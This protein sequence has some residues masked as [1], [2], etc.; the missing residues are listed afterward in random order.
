MEQ[1]SNENAII[2]QPK[3]H[4]R[5]ELDRS[6]VQYMQSVASE[7]SK[8]EK[9]IQDDKEEFEVSLSV[10]DSK[11]CPIQTKEYLCGLI[12]KCDWEGS[13]TFVYKDLKSVSSAAKNAITACNKN[14]I[15]ILGLIK[16]LSNCESKLY[17]LMDRSELSKTEMAYILR[18]LC[19]NANI[20]DESIIEL[21]EQSSERAYKLRDRI[22]NL[23]FEMNEKFSEL[24]KLDLPQKGFFDSKFYKVAVG[25]IA[26]SSLVFC[27]FSLIF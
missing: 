12:K 4:E 21:F 24:E 5:S 25:I 15:S 18:D 6:L 11:K 2:V 14:M 27:V 19:E 20:K 13:F 22:N 16:K 1:N 26:I 7:I 8:I 3:M 9:E 17:D 23:R 10:L